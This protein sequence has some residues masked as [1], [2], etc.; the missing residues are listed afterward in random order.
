MQ[1]PGE[2]IENLFA[3]FLSLVNKMKANIT[4]M[5]YDDHAR[6]LK[7]LHALDLDVWGT[8]VEAIIESANYETL[9]TDELSS[10]LKSKEIDIQFRQKA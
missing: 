1:S 4:V 8:K 9:T 3:R 6:A 2:S 5:P 10:K 7:L